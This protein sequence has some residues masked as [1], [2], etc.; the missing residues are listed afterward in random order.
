MSCRAV[1]LGVDQ[2]MGIELCI[3]MLNMGC[4]VSGGWTKDKNERLLSLEAFYPEQFQLIRMNP[5]SEKSMETAAACVRDQFENPDLLICNLH[6]TEYQADWLA[7]DEQIS[8]DHYNRQSLGPLRFVQFFLPLSE[9]GLKRICL[10]SS[11]EGNPT[12][13]GYSESFMSCMHY[14]A[15]HMAFKIMFNHLS[16]QNYTFRIFDFGAAPSEGGTSFEDKAFQACRY[17]IEPLNDEKNLVMRDEF[18]VE[19]SF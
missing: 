5:A 6:H 15:L 3:R 16:R 12:T 1:I 9:E 10:V 18:S 2:P 13:T 4:T 11:A 14:A 17:F 8:L 19:K 7:L